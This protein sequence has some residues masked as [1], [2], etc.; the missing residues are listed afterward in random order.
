MARAIAAV[1]R[2]KLKEKHPVVQFQASAGFG[3]HGTEA[4]QVVPVFRVEEILEGEDNA[5][6]HLTREDV[7]LYVNAE[8]GITGG[9]VFERIHALLAGR[10]FHGSSR[11]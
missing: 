6:A 5:V 7:A 9:G 11:G 2:S 10:P 8:D 4:R 3:H 1:A